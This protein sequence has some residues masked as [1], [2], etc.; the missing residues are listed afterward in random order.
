[1]KRIQINLKKS[2]KIFFA[3]DF[4]LGAPD[5]VSSKSR[6]KKIIKWL[7]SIENCAQ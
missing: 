7:D 2:K 5:E 3:G 1:M 6:E 4:H